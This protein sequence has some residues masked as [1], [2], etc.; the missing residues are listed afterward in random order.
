MIAGVK[1]TLV[2]FR[3]ERGLAPPSSILRSRR[4]A[5]S[6]GFRKGW[7]HVR[8]PGNRTSS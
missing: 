4:V 7:R 2:A 1:P 6:N 5:V 8:D 3:E